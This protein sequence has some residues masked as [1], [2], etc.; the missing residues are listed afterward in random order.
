MSVGGCWRVGGRGGWA[1]DGLNV[2][3]DRKDRGWRDC[4]SGQEIEGV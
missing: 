4:D 3:V 1:R 2:R